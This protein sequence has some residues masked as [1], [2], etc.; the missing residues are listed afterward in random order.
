LPSYHTIVLPSADRSIPPMQTTM[1]AK[2]VAGFD[3]NVYEVRDC[4]RAAPGN[5]PKFDVPNFFI[6]GSFSATSG[7][8]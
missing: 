6:T 4:G 5:G 3:Q 1:P 7:K 8:T 2:V